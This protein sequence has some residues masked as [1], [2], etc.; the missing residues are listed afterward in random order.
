[1]TKMVTSPTIY[2]IKIWINWFEVGHEDLYL[3]NKQTNK[4]K[5]SLGSSKMYPA[6]KTIASLR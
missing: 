4:Q 6:S 1:M 5:C 3:E 2:P